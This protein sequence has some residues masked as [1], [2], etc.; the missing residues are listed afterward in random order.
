MKQEYKE[1]SKCNQE[2]KKTARN[3]C[4]AYPEVHL[5]I[6]FSS[7]RS[8]SAQ[9]TMDNDWLHT[10]NAVGCSSSHGDRIQGH[11]I[12]GRSPFTE[13][14]IFRSD[15]EVLART[16]SSTWPSSASGVAEETT[17]QRH[18]RHPHQQNHRGAQPP[19]QR[20]LSNSDQ[21][22]ERGRRRCGQRTHPHP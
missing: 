19:R 22:H 1:A 11:W 3:S 18:Q 4:A 10:H 20:Q 21:G 16:N 7:S 5:T 15:I 12:S 9:H 2:K 14:L 8:G 17:Q 13:K 6:S